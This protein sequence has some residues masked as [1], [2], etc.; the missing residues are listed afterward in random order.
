MRV[1]AL[2]ALLAVST[3]CASTESETSTTFP[4]EGRDAFLAR[5]SVL[6]RVDAPGGVVLFNP[7]IARVVDSS[8]TAYPV[9]HPLHLVSEVEMDDRVMLRLRFPEEADVEYLLV[10]TDGM[11]GD[12][13]FYLLRES[14][15]ARWSVEWGEVIAI[16]SYAGI[17]VFQ[18]TNSTYAKRRR[19][20]VQNHDLTEV[21]PAQYEIN[22][23]SAAVD[24]VLVQSSP[25][26]SSAARW[27]VP[28]DT[29]VIVSSDDQRRD[30][31]M[32]FRVREAR[33]RLGWAWLRDS[34]CP[35]AQVRGICFNGD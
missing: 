10:Q 33:G 3:A 35:A 21:R 34:Q 8:R 13:G 26:D 2:S 16:P 1:L 28:G 22:L 25:T 29:I 5:F 9:G 24:S 23:R 11:S 14:D 4:D 6:Q 17:E 7:D 31:R 27:L 18:R 30:G 19:L 12:P 20:R 15:A 32:L